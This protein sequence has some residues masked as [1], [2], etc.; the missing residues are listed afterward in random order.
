[1]KKAK[2]TI[3]KLSFFFAAEYGKLSFYVGDGY[4]YRRIKYIW[5][6]GKQ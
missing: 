3:K 6:R 1:M 2:N 5:R 4:E